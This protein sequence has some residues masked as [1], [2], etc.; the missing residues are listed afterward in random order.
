MEWGIRRRDRKKTEHDQGLSLT[1][2]TEPIKECR[3]CGLPPAT[4][5][6]D[7]S[8][9]RDTDHFG[10]VPGVATL[11][12]WSARLAALD[13]AV[14][15][16]RGRGVFDLGVLAACGG[17]LVAISFAI[18]RWRV[19]ADHYRAYTALFVIA[20][21]IYALAA[22]WVVRRRPPVRATLALLFVVAFAARLV[23]VP[24]TATIS[25]DIA[26]YVWDGRI[27]AAGINP[28]RYA[29]S[30]PALAGFR[31]ATIYPRINRKPVPTIYPPVAQGIFRALY[32]LRADSV[33]WT[34]LAF[35]LLD[36]VAVG[37]LVVLLLRVGMRPEWAL[38]YAWHPLLMIEV[39]HSG[40]VDVVAVLFVL[41]A[42]QAR[43]GNRYARAGVLLACAMLVKF[44]ALVALP[45]LLPAPRRAGWLRLPVALATTAALA[46]LPFL[47]VGARVLGYLPG[48]VQEEG[49]ASG[50]RYYL[51]RQAVQF[52]T[53]LPGDIPHRLARSPLG[54]LSVTAWY[55]AGVVVVM[56][57]LAGWCWL[58]PMAVRREIAD[59]MAILFIVLLTLATPSQPW[60]T[61]LLLACVPLLRG[62]LLTAASIVVATA[63]FD[64][65][66]WW[67][68][69]RPAWPYL[70]TYD[71]RAVALLVLVTGA[72]IAWRR[73]SAGAD[74]RRPYSCAAA[75]VERDRRLGRA[76]A[77]SCQ[78]SPSGISTC[79]PS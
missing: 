8:A 71:G 17:V 50:A 25:D 10:D 14:G 20:L 15:R 24:Q 35:S 60:Y 78:R 26:R 28:Y 23:F 29:P 55:Q 38:L 32:A 47:S 43:I 41:L 1:S 4:T 53:A 13:S 21:G 42:L 12:E 54:L 49:I 37:V 66:H 56:V 19:V 58:H 75:H 11:R 9:N 48:Y 52:V 73:R 31:D 2:P 79:R 7:S 46:Y 76:P 67:Y 33:A 57:A 74:R 5:G 72:T 51:L 34:K 39:G 18:A 40:H 6:M 65:L 77:S 64:Y 69:S 3:G 63:G 16:A 68:P 70:I 59:R 62:Y 22:C 36:L 45:A 44:Y 61:L 27:Q 30:D